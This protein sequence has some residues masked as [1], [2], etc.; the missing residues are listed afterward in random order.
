MC[1]KICI[2]NRKR[3]QIRNSNKSRFTGQLQ[4]Q[5]VS[6]SEENTGSPLQVTFSSHVIDDQR[7]L[8]KPSAQSSD[9]DSKGCVVMEGVGIPPHGPSSENFAMNWNSSYNMVEY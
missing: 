3:S 6:S 7:D 8:N 2:A 4:P 1:L 5:S 9:V